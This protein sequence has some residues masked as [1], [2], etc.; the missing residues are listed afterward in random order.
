MR[1][2]TIGHCLPNFISAPLFGDRK[3]FGLTAQ[4]DDPCWREWQGRYLD[5]YYATQKQSVDKIVN[6]AGY[7]IMFEVDISGEKVLEIG[8]R[9]IHHIDSWNGIPDRYVIADIQ[10]E[11]LDIT[12][13]KLRLN[14]IRF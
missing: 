12:A 13:A 10:R 11:M 3:L 9:D 6:D 4:R 2:F 14:G 8:P 7:C 5:F 1:Y